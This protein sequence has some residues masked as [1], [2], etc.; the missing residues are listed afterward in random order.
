[1]SEK[2]K[3]ASQSSLQPAIGANGAINFIFGSGHLSIVC[4][5][6]QV[7]DIELEP[8]ESVNGVNLETECAG[9]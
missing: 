8:G 4:A 9:S 6:L 2:W 7:C 3:S 5:V 1:M